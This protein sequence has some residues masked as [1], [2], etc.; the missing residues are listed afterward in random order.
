MYR[1]GVGK[2]KISGFFV[3][4]ECGRKQP[5]ADTNSDNGINEA[6]AHFIGWRWDGEGWKCPFCLGWRSNVEV[7][8][9]EQKKY[10]NG[11]E[12]EPKKPRLLIDLSIYER[13]N[14]Q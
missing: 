14:P 2:M 8:R 4:K 3:C 12:K 9:L 1:K 10:L 11:K 6:E 5:Y 7:H 13:G